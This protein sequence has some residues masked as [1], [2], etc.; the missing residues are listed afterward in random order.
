MKE[1]FTVITMKTKN[2]KTLYLKE[3]FGK[4]LEWTFN[5]QEAIWFPLV[6]DAEK[7]AKNYFK[8]FNNYGFETFEYY[9]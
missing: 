7:C 6:I 8:T 9:I 5:K 3:G 1:N 2:G 4:S